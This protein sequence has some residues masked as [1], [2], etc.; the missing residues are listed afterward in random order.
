[1]IVSS[2]DHLFKNGKTLLWVVALIAALCSQILPIP[3]AHAAAVS[4]IAPSPCD[5]TYFEALSSRAWMEAQREI[6][7][8]QNFILKPDS[9]FQY[10][11]FDL[12]MRELADHAEN[13]LSEAAAYGAPLGTSS[14]DNA[15]DTLVMNAL[16]NYIANNFN[17]ANLLS[18]H[19]AAAGITGS[20]PSTVAGVPIPYS[21]DVMGRVWQAAKCMNFVSYPA[22]DG[23]YTFQEYV[24]N[25]EHRHLPAMCVANIPILTTAYTTNLTASGTT[26]PWTNDPL[27][28]YFKM[29]DAEGT[30]AAVPTACT[31]DCK[32]TGAPIPTGITVF[33]PGKDPSAFEEHVCLQAGCRY[34]PGGPDELYPGSSPAAG[35]YAR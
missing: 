35:C 11:C 9:V 32:C 15:L 2:L 24:T 4:T 3:S 27:Q 19:Q 12:H 25:P 22:H 31:G 1:M 6:T 29:T 17:A 20:L 5:S 33:R 28:T 34:Y 26:G 30:D 10:S 23:F 14:M 13:M 7:Q 21:C 18:G 8:N 16:Q